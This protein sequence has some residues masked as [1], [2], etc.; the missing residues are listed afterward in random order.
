MPF[1]ALPF[2]CGKCGLTVTCVNS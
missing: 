1:S 2:A